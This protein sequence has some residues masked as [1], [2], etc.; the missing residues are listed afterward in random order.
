VRAG[1]DRGVDGGQHR[2]ADEQREQ[3]RRLVAG[4]RAHHVRGNGLRLL[5]AR[6]AQHRQVADVHQ[7][8]QRR[9]DQHPADQDARH[10]APRIAHFA[11]ART[12]YAMGRDFPMFRSLGAW[13]DRGSTPA[14]ALVVQG[15]ITL[16]LVAASAATPDGFNAMVAYTS[17]V[18]WTFFLLTGLT[19]FV[20]RR[21][22]GDHPVFRVPLHPVVT[23]ERLWDAQLSGNP[24]D[25]TVVTANLCIA[26]CC[27]K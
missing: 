7:E 16:A 5:D 20:F 25:R 10:V 19:L 26:L 8:V 2:D 21:R 22:G 14:N 27:G 4:D 1:E 13:R 17:P 23:D 15:V 12:N 24:L 11:G 9:H 3:H 6:V 18:F